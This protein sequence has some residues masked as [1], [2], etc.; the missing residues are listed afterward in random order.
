MYVFYDSPVFPDSLVAPCPPETPTYLQAQTHMPQLSESTPWNAIFRVVSRQNRRRAQQSSHWVTIERTRVV[1]GETEKG[2]I[3]SIARG[4]RSPGRR[5]IN[6]RVGTPADTCGPTLYMTP[7]H[8]GSGHVPAN[9]RTVCCRGVLS[10]AR[11]S[12][13]LVSVLP[14][15]AR[16]QAHPCQP[17]QRGISTRA[18]A[19]GAG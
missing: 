4:W 10:S 11:L 14:L 3:H 13:P 15:R 16:R 8:A 5:P 7:V 2:G 1:L 9:T 12:S 18:A 17:R 6:G 19:V